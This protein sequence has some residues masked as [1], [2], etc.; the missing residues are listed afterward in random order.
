ML[1]TRYNFPNN[2]IQI[3]TPVIASSFQINTKLQF[4][5]TITLI[6]RLRHHFRHIYFFLAILQ[7]VYLSKRLLKQDKQRQNNT[8]NQ[9]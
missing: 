2:T 9:A 3:P 6:T 4:Q 5:N 8:H 1:I 7:F